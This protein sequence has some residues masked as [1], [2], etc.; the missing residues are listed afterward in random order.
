MLYLDSESRN[1][2]SK[3]HIWKHIYSNNKL[4]KTKKKDRKEKF[5]ARK[6]LCGTDSKDPAL[7]Q[8]WF[9]SQLKFRFNLWPRNFHM[10][11]LWPKKKKKK[12]KKKSVKYV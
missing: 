11:Q 6:L 7:L 8:L 1:I 5:S 9:R 10:L 2:Y 4:T 3:A 12:K